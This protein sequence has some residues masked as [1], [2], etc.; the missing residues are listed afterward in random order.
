MKLLSNLEKALDREIEAIDED[1][2]LTNAEKSEQ[3]REL[4]REFD[5]T[6]QAWFGQNED[7]DE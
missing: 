6:E 2:S 7:E 3:I 1:E 4:Y 5:E